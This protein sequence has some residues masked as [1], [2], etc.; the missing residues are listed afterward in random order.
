MSAIY[1]VQQGAAQPP[2]GDRAPEPNG[3]E[4]PLADIVN[5]AWQKAELLIR[6]ELQLALADA[7]ERVDSL[8]SELNGQVEQLEEELLAKALGSVI[9]LLGAGAL[10]AALVLLLA[11]ALPAWLAALVVGAVIAGAGVLLLLKPSYA[12][13]ALHV[14]R[15]APERRAQQ[16]NKDLNRVKEATK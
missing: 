11:Q 2:G 15:T 12:R 14:R 1:E 9:V 3:H 10:M 5:D 7:Q 13:R 6:S 16:S 4:R 8:K